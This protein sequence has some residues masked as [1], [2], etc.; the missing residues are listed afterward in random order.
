MGLPR[1]V[2]INRERAQ[3]KA[4]LRSR[5]PNEV[6]KLIRQNIDDRRY[7]VW[8]AVHIWFLYNFKDSSNS[9]TLQQM[10]SLLVD[11]QDLSYEIL[12]HYFDKIGLPKATA[13]HQCLDTDE[14]RRGTPPIDPRTQLFL[15]KDVLQWVDLKKHAV[16]VIEYLKERARPA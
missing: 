9:C 2:I 5:Q 10:A 7:Q 8:A 4:W 16:G 12:E 14:N 3:I 6:Y 11:C 15:E 1:R 13:M